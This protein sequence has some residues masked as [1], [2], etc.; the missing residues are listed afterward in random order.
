MT[1]DHIC[2]CRFCAPSHALERIATL[3]QNDVTATGDIA[4]VRAA[5]NA[6][7][8]ES[9]EAQFDLDIIASQLGV[10]PSIGVTRQQISERIEALE[11][12]Q[13]EPTP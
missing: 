13:E 2:D 8:E 7:Y 4:R 6:W 10:E 11:M 3:L 1:S 12:M 9:F 5:L